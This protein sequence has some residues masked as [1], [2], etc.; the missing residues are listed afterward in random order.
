M[1]G[2]DP[3]CEPMIHPAVK[4]SIGKRPAGTQPCLT[5]A[6]NHSTGE[7]SQEV[8]PSA[9]QE[10][11]QPSADIRIP[12]YVPPRLPEVIAAVPIR[13]EHRC[14]RKKIHIGN[15]SKWIPVIERTDNSSHRWMVVL[16]F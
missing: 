8:K 7:T 13:G 5:E 15:V 12:R 16:G 9:S 10:E 2:S 1:P 11:V 6:P 14:S 3:A 4:E